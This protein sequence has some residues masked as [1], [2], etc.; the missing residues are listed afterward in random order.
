M[1]DAGA[2]PEEAPYEPD[3]DFKRIARKYWDASHEGRL[4]RAAELAKR[5]VA[6]AE[7]AGW[8]S[9]SLVLARLRLHAAWELHDIRGQRATSGFV[10]SRSDLVVAGWA[11]S[12]EE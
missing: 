8:P 4:E 11:P 6:R 10:A 1:A 9:H 7:A 3:D 2:P 12:E 5:L